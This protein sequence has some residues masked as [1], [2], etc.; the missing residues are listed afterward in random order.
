MHK[1]AQRVAAAP[2]APTRHPLNVDFT[3]QRA[4][5]TR[6]RRLTPQQFDEYN[7]LG[8]TRIENAFTPAE[9][10]AVIAAIDPIEQRREEYM[11]EHQGGRVRLSEADIITFT[12]HIVRESPV[13]SAFAAHPAIK[14]VCHDLIGNG[15][16]KS[17]SMSARSTIP[18]PLRRPGT[19]SPTSGCRG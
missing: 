11:K 1:D 10:A 13:L 9:I 15:R 18:Q 8:F 12:V 2:E 3:W 17:I 16:A 5:G 19:P 4:P 7:E 6:L 14:D